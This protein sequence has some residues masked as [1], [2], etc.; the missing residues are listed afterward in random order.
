VISPFAKA[1]SQATRDAY[2][3]H[4]QT[5]RDE[6]VPLTAGQITDNQALKYFEH[7]LNPN[8]STHMLEGFTRAAERR[9]GVENPTGVIE[10]GAGGTV[11]TL[12]NNVGNR[13]ENMQRNSTLHVDAPLLQDLLNTH[14]AYT[15]VPGLYSDEVVNTVRGAMQRVGEIARHPTVH[16]MTGEEYQTLT[17]DLRRAARGTTDPARASALHD[18]TEALDNAMERSIRRTNPDLAGQWQAARTDYKRALVLE[19]AAT[20]AGESPARGI[21][22]PAQLA[23][24]AKAIY[25]KRAYER[26]HDNFS[27]LANA[28][29]AVLKALP[30]S[31]TAGHAVAKALF[32]VP[33]HLIGGGGGFL[34]G[35]HSGIGE[36]AIGGLL[37]GEGAA[38]IIE[39]GLKTGARGVKAVIDPYLR[40]QLAAGA[41]RPWE[42]IPG[43]LSAAQGVRQ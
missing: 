12:L 42:T 16:T 11:D 23:S 1:G 25:G 6:G 3:G 18:I 17:S 24:A 30:D 4:V 20:A 8:H 26:G 33:A 37:I 5:L 43:L 36:G 15:R 34:A 9:A 27:D 21:I 28:G 29:A 13:F 41:T 10:H 39:H 7:N 31:G 22:T 19:R 40:N 35:T 38:P 2:A 32:K 14:D